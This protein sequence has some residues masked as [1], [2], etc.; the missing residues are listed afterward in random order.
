MSLA[1]EAIS[2]GDLQAAIQDHFT[3]KRRDLSPPLVKNATISADASL[4]VRG[5]PALNKQ[6]LVIYREA[7]RVLPYRDALV[8]AGLNPVMREANR[9]LSLYGSEG[10][11]LTGGPDVD[12]GLYGET[13]R[14]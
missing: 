1:D 7:D 10:L 8:A 5:V 11:L 4:Q 14:A 12:P 2:G 13:R 3:R 6:V 9:P